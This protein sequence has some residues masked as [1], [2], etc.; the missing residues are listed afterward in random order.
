[1]LTALWLTTPALTYSYT[2]NPSFFAAV[3]P[4][5]SF[6]LLK[7]DAYPDLSVLTIR[8]F[9]AKFTK[10]GYFFVIELRPV[11]DFENQNSDLVISPIIG[12]SL[13]GGFN[14]LFLAEFP[15]SQVTIDN[16]GMLYQ[17]G[18]NKNF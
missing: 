13:G 4:Q 6:H 11:F 12:K 15:T 7:D 10:T 8:S 9:L 14:L 1:L 5:Y 17:L 16:I 2:I 3:Q 18:F